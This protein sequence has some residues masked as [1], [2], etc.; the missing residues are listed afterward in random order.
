MNRCRVLVVYIG[1]GRSQLSEEPVQAHK[2]RSRASNYLW[3]T[4]DQRHLLCTLLI[5]PNPMGSQ[6]SASDLALTSC[7][8]RDLPTWLHPLMGSDI[9]RIVLL[10]TARPVLH[11]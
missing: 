6:K 4:F 10:A 2:E 5:T 8:P 7:S 9:A 3:V 1:I 11:F